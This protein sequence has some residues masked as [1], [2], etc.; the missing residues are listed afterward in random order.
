MSVR[1]LGK[2]LEA[3]IRSKEDQSI[4]G[5]SSFDN[6]SIF[7]ISLKDI[8]TN[9]NQPRIKFEETSILELVES[10]RSKGIISPITVRKVGGKFEIIAG[11]R[12]FRASSILKKSSI[13]AYII[14]VKEDFEMLE[15]ALIE[16]I[17]RE[18]LNPIEE[19]KAFQQLNS[20]FN[21]SQS[22]MAKSLGKSRVYIANSLRL[23]KLPNKII[24]SLINKEIT[25]GHARAILQLKIPN[26]MLK[27][28]K[29]IINDSLS[30]RASETLVKEFIFDSAKI[31]KKYK[32]RVSKN[33]KRTTSIENELIEIFGTKVK[34]KELKKGGMIEI[35]YFSN[36]DLDRLM[37]LIES[38][39]K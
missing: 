34:L 15:L 2:G 3:L 27:L 10:I 23:L 29:R 6:L 18:N 14:D 25:A 5:D 21:I 8:L 4:E 39:V 13:P 12:R 1:R 36:E 28:W 7:K 35:S 17:Q 11:E 30:V 26:L 37:E 24:H 20:K 31:K 22:E 32:Q 9:P 19:A 33:N 16:N 38:I